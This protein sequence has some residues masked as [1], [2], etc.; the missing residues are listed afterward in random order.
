MVTKSDLINLGQSPKCMREAPHLNPLS[1]GEENAK[2]QVRVSQ[3]RL[4]P[5][6]R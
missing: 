2:R 5:F 4:A 3:M 6:M 1:E